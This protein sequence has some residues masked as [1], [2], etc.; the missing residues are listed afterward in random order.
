M[1]TTRRC[2]SGVVT[3]GLVFLL[4]E[5]LFQPTVI[6]VDQA[7]GDDSNDGH[8]IID[9]MKTIKAA[10]ASADHGDIILIAPGVYRETAPIDITKNN[11]SVVGQSLRSVFVHPTPATEENTLSV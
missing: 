5:P 7:N 6:W 1:E 11:V 8:R 4:A 3:I 9:S 10:V 2:L